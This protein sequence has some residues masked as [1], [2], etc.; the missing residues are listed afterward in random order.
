MAQ[1]RQDHQKFLELDTE[2][3]V[4]GPEKPQ[5]FSRYWVNNELPFVGLPDPQHSVL[6]LY[7]QEIKLFKWGRMP[8]MVVI[9]KTGLVRFVHYGHNMSDIP[10]NT[11]VLETLESLNKS[12]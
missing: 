11:D 2:I 8:A 10:E 12:K 1:L 7:G 5:N 6:K 4:V 9:D 3:I